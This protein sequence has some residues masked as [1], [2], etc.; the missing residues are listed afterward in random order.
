MAGENEFGKCQICGNEGIIE[1]TYFRY[2]IKCECHSPHHFEIVFHCKDCIPK[3]PAETKII[4]NTKN[5]CKL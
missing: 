3:E 2:D 5:L 1:R 4:I